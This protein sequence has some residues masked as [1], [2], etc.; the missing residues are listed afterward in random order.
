MAIT[1]AEI[2]EAILRAT[3]IAEEFANGAAGDNRNAPVRSIINGTI[4]TFLREMA[5]SGFTLQEA[6]DGRPDA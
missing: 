2:E 3:R 1:E 5:K 4:Q 6:K